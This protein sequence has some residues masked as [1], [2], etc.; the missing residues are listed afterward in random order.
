MRNS[1]FPGSALSDG[2]SENP[3]LF[4]T[5]E[6]AAVSACVAVCAVVCKIA[7]IML[8]RGKVSENLP[9]RK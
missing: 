4:R 2:K 6:G 7:G 9:L 1:V 5:E 8:L 3:I